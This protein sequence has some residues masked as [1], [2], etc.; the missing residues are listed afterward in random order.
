[1]VSVMLNEG[2]NDLERLLDRLSKA[3]TDPGEIHVCPVC[4]GDLHVRFEPYIRDGKSFLGLHAFCE[5]CDAAIAT[6]YAQLPPE[7]LQKSASSQTMT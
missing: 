3:T 1:M 4:G 2:Y 7:W 6:D 5:S